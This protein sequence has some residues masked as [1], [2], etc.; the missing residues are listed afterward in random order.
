MEHFLTSDG[1]PVRELEL[2]ASVELQGNQS[3]GCH[4]DDP[5]DEEEQQQQGNVPAGDKFSG[6]MQTSI[7]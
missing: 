1:F 6:E 5:R 3:I 7:C 4:H 2:D